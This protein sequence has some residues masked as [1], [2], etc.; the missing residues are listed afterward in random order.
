MEAFVPLFFI[1]TFYYTIKM[2]KLKYVISLALL[3]GSIDIAPEIGVSLGIALGFYAL[4]NKKAWDKKTRNK[5]IRYC[6]ATIIIS[7]IVF[8]AYQKLIDYMNY[9]YLSG[10][11][12]TLPLL[13]RSIPYSSGV[14]DAI[15]P[16]IKGGFAASMQIYSYPWRLLLTMFSI[17]AGLGVFFMFDPLFAILFILPWLFMVF[18][19]SDIWFIKPWHQYFGLALGGIAAFNILSVKNMKVKVPNATQIALIG[20]IISIVLTIISIPLF[21]TTTKFG[22]GGVQEEMLFHVSPLMHN[23]IKSMDWAISTI[24]KNATI[25]APDYIAGHMTN[26]RY[27]EYLSSG[28]IASSN[29]PGI[30]EYSEFYEPEYIIIDQNDA[31]NPSQISYFQTDQYYL[32]TNKS[33]AI[34]EENKSVIVLK[35]I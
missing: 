17:F 33:Y 20:V 11:Y 22:L 9:L 1:L 6:I 15:I 30:L 27:M 18:F 28:P 3:L 2:D 7:L 5:I 13:L 34:Y 24:P 4:F 32:Q 31:I 8:F 26:R 35:K 10:H 16:T 19:V 23:Q 29:S 21:N 25:M 14:I 12:Q